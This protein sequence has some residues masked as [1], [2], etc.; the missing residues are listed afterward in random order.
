MVTDR[1]TDRIG[2]EPIVS[3]SVNLTG[4]E[5]ETVRV[6]GPLLSHFNNVITQ[7]TLIYENTQYL[8]YFFLL[9]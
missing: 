2:S 1:L 4:T 3:I 8:R 7:S 9:K 5:T 6:N